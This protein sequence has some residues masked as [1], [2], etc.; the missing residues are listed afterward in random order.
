MVTSSPAGIDC[1]A[2]CTG[3]FTAG[4]AVSLSAVGS[5]G[6]VFSGWSGPC[7]GDAACEV[8]AATDRFI[9]AAF[10]ASSMLVAV[11][12]VIGETQAA[13]SMAITGAGLVVGAVT[14][15]SSSTVASGDV[16]SGSPAAGTNVASASAVN[17]VVST[18]G[19]SGGG[20][21]GGAGFDL[22]ALGALLAALMGRLASKAGIEEQ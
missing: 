20:Y 1:G 22:L 14:Q 17:L 19:S 12:N 9:T 3:R 5:S 13:A 7:T 10:S 16:I 11:P 4:T 8:T 15:R 6:A 21:G 18:G 2:S